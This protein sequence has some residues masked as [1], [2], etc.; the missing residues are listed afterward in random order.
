LVSR[1]WVAFIAALSTLIPTIHGW[2]ILPTAIVVALAPV[3]L[4]VFSISRPMTHSRIF[5]SKL[6]LV[7]W[8]WI[9]GI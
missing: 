2:A 9:S 8:I 6:S 4:L 3:R 1:A 7:S 5:T